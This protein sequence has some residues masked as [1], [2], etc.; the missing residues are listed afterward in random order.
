MNRHPG[1]WAAHNTFIAG[2]LLLTSCSG[3]PPQTGASYAA[4]AGLSPLGSLSFAVDPSTTYQTMAGFGVGFG[5]RSLKLM[6]A[7]AKPQ[8]RERAFDLLY[9]DPGLRLNIVRLTISAEAQPI[10]CGGGARGPCYD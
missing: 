2:L 4:T 6:E 5:S 10:A 7:I 3:P 9:G 1:V 8:D